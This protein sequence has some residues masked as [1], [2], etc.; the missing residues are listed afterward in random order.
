M[1]V[2]YRFFNKFGDL[3]IGKFGI[4]RCDVIIVYWKLYICKL[5]K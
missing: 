2:L 5:Y 1:I 3:N 4:D